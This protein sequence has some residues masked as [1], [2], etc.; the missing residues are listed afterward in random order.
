M[1]LAREH[2]PVPEVLRVVPVPGAMPVPDPATADGTERPVVRPVMVL[3]YVDG[4]P[5]SDALG[6]G[7]GGPNEPGDMNELGVVV[8][9]AFGDIG[10]VELARPGFFAGP[11]LAV[12][13]M[14]PWSKQLPGMAVN[15]MDRAPGSRL[16]PAA[17]QAW[18]DL[19]TVHAPALASIDA[20]ARLVH[21]DA[22][23]K[24]VLVTSTAGGWRVDAVLD[25]EFSFSGCPYADYANMTRFGGTY[26]D[27][28][29]SGFRAGFE[30]RV[31]CGMD[32]DWSYLGRVMD[33]FALSDLVTRPEG[34]PVADQAAAEI[35]RWIADGVPA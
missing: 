5:L 19:C 31:P 4:T 11:D 2:V 34:H 23:P 24:N 13:D 12:G 33:M 10:A 26:P 8:G 30:S 29:V 18:I 35:L 20:Q 15:C 9:E 17:R 32:G 22:N 14:P 1:D 3:E 27:E 25:W 16:D 28:F 7:V 6:D 21:A